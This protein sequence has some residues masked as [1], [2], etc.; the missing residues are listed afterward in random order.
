MNLRK[1]EIT[2]ARAIAAYKVMRNVDYS[3]VKERAGGGEGRVVRKGSGSVAIS[4]SHYASSLWPG[5]A[6]PEPSLGRER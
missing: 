4:T 1:Q 6:Q 5:V 3:V 2:E